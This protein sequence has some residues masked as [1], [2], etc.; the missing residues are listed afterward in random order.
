MLSEPDLGLVKGIRRSR[1]TTRRG[2]DR[3]GANAMNSSRIV[4]AVASVLVLG[5][6]LLGAS[7]LRSIYESIGKPFAGFLVFPHGVVGPGFS[8]P[9]PNSDEATGV[10]YLDRVV[11]V[12]GQEVRS[13]QE[14]QR[15][16]AEAGLGSLLSYTLERPGEGRLEVTV[17]VEPLPALFFWQIVLPLAIAGVL[18]LLIGALPVLMRPDLPSARAL[19]I[20]SWS[21]STNYCLLAF[22]YFWVYD[23]V[24]F[25]YPLGALT[26]ASLFHL[27]LT[28]PERR[29]PMGTSAQSISL[30][31][32]YGLF[33]G[34][35]LLNIY[36]VLNPPGLTTLLDSL[37]V[38][39][40]A[41]GCVAFLA[42]CLYASFRGET[43]ESKHRARIALAGPAMAFVIL[44]AILIPTLSGDTKLPPQIYQIPLFLMPLTFAYAIL[45]HNV[46]EFGSV[47]RSAIA[48][49]LLLLVVGVIAFG[50]FDVARSLMEVDR[51]WL[52]ALA[53]V[54]VLLLLAP[55]LS[56]LRPR[57]ERAVQ[58]L[59]F[60]AQRRT[61]VRFREAGRA[62]VDLRSV[63]EVAGLLESA[64]REALHAGSFSLVYGPVSEPLRVAGGKAIP[65]AFLA[66]PALSRFLEGDELADCDDQHRDSSEIEAIKAQLKE[67]A[68]ALAVPLP[69]GEGFRGGLFLGPRTDERLYTSDDE[70]LLETLALQSSSALANAR[71]WDE[72]NELR[73]RLEEE[74]VTLRREIQLQEGF[75]EIVGESAG[76]REAMAQV[77]Q[78]APTEA[79]VI[80]IG[81]TGTGKELIVRALHR[82]SGRS[83]G[84]MVKLA[85]AAIPESLVESELFGHEKG[86]FTGATQSKPGR[87]ELADGGILFL[88][89]VDT[90]SL[91]VQAKLLRAIQEGEIQRVGSAT[92]R[93]VDIRVVAATNRDLLADARKG[94]FREDLYY[95]M[96]VVPIRLPALRERREDIPLLVQSFIEQES[97]KL[98]QEIRPVAP[99][100]L[101]QFKSH[102]WPGNIREMRNAVERA[103]VMSQGPVIRLPDSGFGL[104]ESP[105]PE[106]ASESAT[107]VGLDARPLSERV[108]DL[109]AELIRAAL[110]ESE[111]NQSRAAERLGLHRQSLNRMIR[112]LG[113][114][115]SSR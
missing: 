89:D 27:A 56:T 74:N 15:L 14:V 92:T 80:V 98:G 57:M 25:L 101:R 47:L 63:E 67:S 75:E 3:K 21:Y 64:T 26:K 94:L 61:S 79:N 23:L 29:W 33:L 93:I 6:L 115:P 100:L 31:A 50:T 110:A 37:T 2:A 66:S 38:T 90:L 35:S 41:A 53:S 113:I 83:E 76:I 86:A 28:F 95:R 11:A 58:N 69:A 1:L 65:A 39:S 106:S 91:N 17:P 49:G 105:R 77:E 12:S 97:A 70:Q 51:T 60:P 18:A 84:P 30:F 104:S 72:V 85:C 55:F 24:P 108:R 78:V 107:T 62:L 4:R 16:A 109:K 42:S 46:F 36:S 9:T 99:E 19:F 22:D 7:E 40:L 43:V 13:G 102:D 8:S 59:L 81:E 71:A 73:A 54:G 44:W 48:T 103:V 32:L 10:D 87:F 68:L 20:W 45:R 5:S 96:A 82:L 114:T 88:D 111:G 112:E 52:A 34:L